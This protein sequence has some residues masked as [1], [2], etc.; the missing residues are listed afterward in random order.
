MLRNPASTRPWQH[1]LEPLSGYLLLAAKIYS[2]PREYSGAWNFGPRNKSIRTVQDV[3][4]GIVKYWGAGEI[5]INVQ[6]DVPREAKLLR[7]NCDKSHQILGWY[8]RWDF[9]HAVEKTVYW[10]KKAFNNKQALEI[11]TQQIEDYMEQN[12]D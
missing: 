9:D 2:S 1:V 4:E 7:L 11:S 12:N 3:A 8:P 10:Y 5:R 6:S